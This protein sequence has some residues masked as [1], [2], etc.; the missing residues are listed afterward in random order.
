MRAPATAGSRTGHRDVT[1]RRVEQQTRIS[2]FDTEQMCLRGVERCRH[3]ALLTRRQPH[4]KL[5]VEQIEQRAVLEVSLVEPREPICGQER[6]FDGHRLA[7]RGPYAVDPDHARAVRDLQ[8]AG[9]PTRSDHDVTR[10]DLRT[11]HE[12]ALAHVL[13][14]RAERHRLR[15][16]RRRDERAAAVNAVR[17]SVCDEPVDLGPNGHPRDAVALG[18]FTLGRQRR[19]R[20]ARG[21]QVGHDLAQLLSL[22]E[23]FGQAPRERLS[24]RRRAQ[25]AIPAFV[26]AFA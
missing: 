12:P 11:G 14:E 16:P 4:S 21:D 19:A 3:D 24:V 6:L 5:V 26:H 2:R 7:V 18:Q 20:L 15:H 22:R 23:A 10:E 8:P 13:R 25:E 17:A 9:D 1:A